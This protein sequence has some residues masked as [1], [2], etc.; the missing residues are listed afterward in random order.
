VER[1]RGAAALVGAGMTYSITDA[2]LILRV[3]L[4]VSHGARRKC[5][6]EAIAYLEAPYP[7]DS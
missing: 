1:G 6:A 4:S 2:L 7:C 3:A 5:T